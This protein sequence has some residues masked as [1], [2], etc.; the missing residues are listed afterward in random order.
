MSV[1]ES[2]QR[3]LNWL[4]TPHHLEP[5]LEMETRPIAKLPLEMEIVYCTISGSGAALKFP[6]T[7]LFLATGASPVRN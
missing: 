7:M 3:G 2:I 6:L 1:V 4:A 5:H